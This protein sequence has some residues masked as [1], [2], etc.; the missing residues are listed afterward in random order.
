MV[1]APNGD[2]AARGFRDDFLGRLTLRTGRVVRPQGDFSRRF[3]RER[4]G[5]DKP[6]NEKHSRGFHTFPLVLVHVLAPIGV[7]SRHSTFTLIPR[8]S[9]PVPSSVPNSSPLAVALPAA[10]TMPP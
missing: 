8:F 3:H 9:S 2:L 6:Q 1:N 7:A 5:R 10:L 4:D